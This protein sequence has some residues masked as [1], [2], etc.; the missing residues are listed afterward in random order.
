MNRPKIHIRNTSAMTLVELLVAT[1]LVGIVM[2]GTV[3]VDFAIHNIKKNNTDSAT[4]A[5]QTSAAMIE[6]TSHIQK[7]V[8]DAQDL[9]IQID[10]GTPKTWFCVREDTDNNP[11]DY[12]GDTWTCYYK[13]TGA[14]NPNIYTCVK[15]SDSS[16]H[17]V[18]NGTCNTAVDRSIGTAACGGSWPTVDCTNYQLIYSL[19]NDPATNQFYF[20]LSLKSRAYPTQLQDPNAKMKNPEYSLSSHITPMGH[21]F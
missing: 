16:G 15:S 18:G 20:D 9:G 8:G 7:A 19:A 4:L 10:T 13:P 17:L 11:D 12:T 1:A 6:M 5:M 2:L 14:A 3:S 21:S